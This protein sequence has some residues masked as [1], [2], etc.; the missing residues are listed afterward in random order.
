MQGLID[1]AAQACG[2][3]ACFYSAPGGRGRRSVISDNGGQTNEGFILVADNTC[4]SFAHSVAPAE[5]ACVLTLALETGV[6]WL[7]QLISAAVYTSGIL[8]GLLLIEMMPGTRPG[9]VS[10]VQPD[11]Q[12]HER[13][14]ALASA[15]EWKGPAVLVPAMRLWA[16]SLAERLEKMRLQ[17]EAGTMTRALDSVLLTLENLLSTDSRLH[18]ADAGATGMLPSAVLQ[19]TSTKLRADLW[20]CDFDKQQ[21]VGNNSGH[22]DGERVDVNSTFAG[23]A[24]CSSKSDIFCAHGVVDDRNPQNDSVNGETE[25]KICI[26]I[27]P[28]SVSK[29]GAV[30][31]RVILQLTNV[32]RTKTSETPD[33]RIDHFELVGAELLQNSTLSSVVWIRDRF[34]QLIATERQRA[35]I[36]RVVAQLE[37]TDSVT[38]AIDTLEQE[39]GNVM[40]CEACTVFFVDNRQAEIWAPPTADRVGI[41][42]GFDEGLVGYVAMRAREDRENDN[43]AVITNDP[44]SCPLWSGDVGTDWVTRNLLTAPVTSKGTHK[45]VLAVIQLCNKITNPGDS[46]AEASTSHYMHIEGFTSM[47]A[48]LMSELAH[49]IGEFIQRHVLGVLWAKARYD[50][51][52]LASSAGGDSGDLDD[53]PSIAF[54][55]YQLKHEE[56]QPTTKSFQKRGTEM[57]LEPSMVP[58]EHANLDQWSL[59]YW[60]LSHDEEHGLLV[61]ALRKCGV[62]SEL[63]LSRQHVYRFFMAVRQRYRT[64]IPYHNFKH[65]MSTLHY[66]FKMV[67]ATDCWTELPVTSLM[68]LL[69]GA[70][71]HDVDHRGRNNAFEVVTR[72]ELALRYNDSSPLE[73][74]HCALAFEIAIN[75]PEDKCNF[76]L[77]LCD[78]E[79]EA[80]RKGMVS[81]IL[82]T[83]M[84]H[85]GAHVEDVQMYLEKAISGENHQML[86]GIILH[87]ADISNP[88]MPSEIA[89]RWGKCVCEE[90]TDQANAERDLGIPVTPFMANL[91]TPEAIYRNH[92]GFIDFVIQPLADPMFQAFPGLH[93]CREFLRENREAWDLTLQSRPQSQQMQRAESDAGVES[94]TFGPSV[95]VSIAATDTVPE[96]QM[97]SPQQERQRAIRRSNFGNIASEKSKN[98]SRHTVM[99]PEFSK[100]PTNKTFFKVATLGAT[101]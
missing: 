48:E 11:A 25:G 68:A 5:H 95:T 10:R 90:F 14:R 67:Q 57:E 12:D 62:L 85:H 73:N 29:P 59:Y 89:E 4:C 1:S 32:R 66:A 92:C 36:Q 54:E 100:A 63:N 30:P 17:E 15:V 60:D 7:G 40:G 93:P 51:A 74:H 56:E 28:P 96:G 52:A 77:N 21:L 76:F 41:C 91:D 53:I 42:V 78:E 94:M 82:A 87:A 75:S 3:R 70:L 24:M 27:L 43:S 101:I 71:C 38:E 88:M 61:Q 80:V 65:A 26:P 79:F 13:I 81:C 64:D 34:L 58:A 35:G 49:A 22:K 97:L 8:E 86:M 98:A 47:D 37:N 33:D 84:K 55:Y 39:V 18:E 72:S 16:A 46:T 2:G 19:G 31:S 44:R 9:T 69:M 50:N 45:S 20:A 99:I 6:A 23:K 83:D